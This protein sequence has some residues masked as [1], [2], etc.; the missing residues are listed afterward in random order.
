MELEVYKQFFTG[1]WMASVFPF[2]V[3]VFLGIKRAMWS[4]A[5]GGESPSA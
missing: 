1:F 3:G 5:F 2:V 4:S